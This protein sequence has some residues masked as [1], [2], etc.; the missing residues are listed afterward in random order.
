M[1]AVIFVLDGLGGLVVVV[2]V[3]HDV[4]VLKIYTFVVLNNYCFYQLLF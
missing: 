1:D 3:F 4:F 2:V